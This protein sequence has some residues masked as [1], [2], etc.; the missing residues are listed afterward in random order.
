MLMNTFFLFMLLQAHLTL[1][2]FFFFQLDSCSVE[3][4]VYVFN[5]C[6]EVIHFFLFLYYV[7]ICVIWISMGN[8][9]FFKEQPYGKMLLSPL[10]RCY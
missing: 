1:A 10:A 8:K 3:Q 6:T 4:P 7:L 2:C 5:I 9:K